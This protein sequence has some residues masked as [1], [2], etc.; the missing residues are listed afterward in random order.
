MTRRDFA[1][2]AAAAVPAARLFAAE[3]HSIVGG[4]KLG[5][6]TYSFHDLKRTPGQ[7]AVD[8]CI[9]N[10]LYAGCQFCELMSSDV[11]PAGPGRGEAVP[12]GASSPREALR[13]WRIE[14][15]TE[16]FKAVR[17]KFNDAGI[18]IFAYTVNYNAQY[19]DEEIANSFRHA[20]ALGTNIIASSTTVSMAKRIV[21]YAEKAGMNVAFH[22]HTNVKD[23]EQFA[24]PA[25]FA[26]ALAMSPLYRINLDI[27]HFVAA[28]FD[29]VSYIR[30][31][32]QH[33][34]HL[35]V[36]D[37]KKNDGPNMPWGQGDTPYRE[38]LLLVKNNRYDIA[39]MTEMAYPVNVPTREEVKKNM[40]DMR[41]ILS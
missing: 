21:P 32:H 37:K 11:E 25:N 12:A 6:I 20:K 8:E 41:A 33:I 28:G 40:D 2:I 39:A 24:A 18:T 19:S 27:G 10:L 35:H 34:T 15:P 17:K 26:A 23:P 14:T 5:A 29:P 38:V 9:S 30:E 36:K 1:T 13:K 3:P 4:V 7:D 22:G 31:N 16:H